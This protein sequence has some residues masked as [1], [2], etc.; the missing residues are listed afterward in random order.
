M[1][2][3]IRLQRHGKKGKPFYWIVAAD[4]RSKRDGRYLEKIGTYN[5]NTNPANVEINQESAINWLEKGAQPTDTARTLLSY[6]GILLK[7]HLNKGSN[8]SEAEWL[9]GWIAL[10]FLNNPE[11][12]IKHF[13]NMA[14]NAYDPKNR[15]RAAYW[16]AKT[17][18]TLGQQNLAES[19]YIKGSA[20]PTA[21]YGQ[22]SFKK[23]F[24]NKKISF[25]KLP[26]ISNKTKN[27]FDNNQ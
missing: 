23:I 5:P 9:S 15:S 16:C 25:P 13:L 14:K 4:S 24:P 22:L 11:L 7:H 3:K 26:I 20:Y 8:Y 27:D 12:A 21:Y 17:Y 10:S 18:E 6:K 2:V 19:W 1:P